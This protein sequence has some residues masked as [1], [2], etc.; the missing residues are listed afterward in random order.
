MNFSHNKPDSQTQSI[1]RVTYHG[2]KSQEG[3]QQWH[4]NSSILGGY[5][6]QRGDERLGAPPP[7]RYPVAFSGQRQGW[8][9]PKRTL[10]QCTASVCSRSALLGDLFGVSRSMERDLSVLLIYP[11]IFLCVFIVCCLLLGTLILLYVHVC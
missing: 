6:H 10:W 1:G 11:R 4:L 8:K 5:W 3:Q 9:T 7:R 2:L